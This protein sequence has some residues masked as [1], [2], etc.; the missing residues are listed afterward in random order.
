[1]A[2][3][4][5]TEKATPKRRERGAQEGPGRQAPAT[6]AARVVCHRR[7]C[8]RSACVGPAHRRATP[9]ARCA[10]AFALIAHPGD[11]TT[12]GGLQTLLDD[13]RSRRWPRPSAP[14]A[15]VCLAAGVLA[16]VAQVGFQPSLQRAQARLQADQPGHRRARICSA[17]ESLFEA[18]KR[19]AKVAVVGVVAALALVPQLT[20]S[21]RASAS[22]RAR[23]AASWAH[24][25]LG[26]RPARRRSPTSLIA[27]RRLRLAAPPPREVAADEQAGGQGGAQAQDPAAEVRAAHPPPPDAGRPRA[28][29][30]RRPAGRR[31]RHEPDP[32]RR[33]AAL[34]R[35]ASRRP[36]SSPRART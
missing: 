36:R 4:D 18:G 11:V 25:A 32:L 13:R 19:I 3:D 33:R 34:R 35:P 6:S 23:S 24:S 28:H 8:S 20:T 15:G 29:D 21:A 12:G 26:D 10:S 1:M 2:H 14:I 7:R 31:R 27:D 16:N 30:G 9:R 17:A 5:R 22:R